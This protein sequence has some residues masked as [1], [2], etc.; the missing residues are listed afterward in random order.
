MKSGHILAIDQGTTNTKAVLFDATGQL[1]ARASHPLATHSPHSGWVEQDPIG[2]WRSVI[3]AATQC[4]QNISPDSVLAVGISNQRETVVVW[5]RSTGKPLHP[6]IVWQCRRS[7]DVCRALREQGAETFLRGTT[8]LGLDPLFSASKLAWLLDH[9]KGLRQCAENGEVCCGTVDS[10]L[11]WNLTG[12]REHIC[13][14]SNAARTQLLNLHS[15]E[16]DQE[17]L[18]LFRIPAGMLPRIVAS[19]GNLGETAGLGFLADGT[20]LGAALGDSHAALAGQAIFTPGAVKATYG[21][22]SSLMT[23]TD[24]VPP[25]QATLSATVAW[26]RSGRVQYALEGNITMTGAAVEWCG[27]FLGLSRPVEDLVQLAETVSSS[28]G[29]VF[30]PAMCGLGAPHWQS[31]ARGAISGLE[32][33]STAAH[34]ARAALESVCFQVRDVFEEMK[35]TSGRNLSVLYVDG[36]A[37]GN[38]GLMQ[39]QADILNCPVVRARVSELSA[40]GAAYFAGHAVGFW[41]SPESMAALAAP[42]DTFLPRLKVATGEEVYA[43]WKQ[44]VNTTVLEAKAK[45]RETTGHRLPQ[46]CKN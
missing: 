29:V 41:S 35:L 20:M 4:L 17:A 33:A 38:S 42:S 37:T 36:G 16:W 23:L 25:L 12:G 30:V 22:G 10:W 6:A 27:R 44:A 28:E 45:S 9:V 8:G 24:G 40:A 11:L 31:E 34:L 14:L 32:R 26:K 21:T 3:S 18:A 1:I 46:V 19:E 13:D 7:E 2:I 5:E 43:R 39:L 15:C